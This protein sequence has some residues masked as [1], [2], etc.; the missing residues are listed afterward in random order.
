MEIS[1]H[2]G[3]YT[4]TTSTTYSIMAFPSRPVHPHPSLFLLGG[5]FAGSC[6]ES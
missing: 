6:A 2:Y 4:P 1:Y 5:D 3:A